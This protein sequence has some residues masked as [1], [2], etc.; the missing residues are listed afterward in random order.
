MRG[1]ATP[2]IIGSC[3]R[4]FGMKIRWVNFVEIKVFM[5]IDLDIFLIV[6]NYI[7]FGL[8]V[9]ALALAHMGNVDY[10]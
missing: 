7:H 9:T 6:R 2:S 1:A 8:L 5:G 3:P 10:S 4:A